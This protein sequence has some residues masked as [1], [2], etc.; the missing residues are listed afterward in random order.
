MF[1]LKLRMFGRDA[2]SN[3]LYIPVD[4]PVKSYGVA[5]ASCRRYDVMY[6]DISRRQVSNIALRGGAFELWRDTKALTRCHT[7]A[8]NAC[9]AMGVAQ[10]FIMAPNALLLS[11]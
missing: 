4:C 3:L 7:R 9:M 5:E 2:E 11:M 1:L 8:V 10:F 6:L